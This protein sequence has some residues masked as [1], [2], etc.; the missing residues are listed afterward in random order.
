MAVG[1]ENVVLTANEIGLYNTTTG[2]LTKKQN[3]DANYMAW[4][5]GVLVFEHA[6]L[7][8][9]VFDLNRKFHSRVSIATQELKACQL[10]ATY[11]HKSLDAIVRIIEKTLNIKTEIKGEEIIFSGQG[12]E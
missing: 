3:E 11:D 8:S 2:A 6:D 5:T 4:E 12:C 7:E 10:T 9:V 1:S